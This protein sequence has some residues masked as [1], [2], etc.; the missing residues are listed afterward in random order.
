MKRL[1]VRP[2]FRGRGIG[3]ALAN[4][5]ILA[6]KQ[7]G[8]RAMRL[9]TLPSMTEAHSLYREIG[10]REITAYRHNPVSGTRF[11]ELDLSGAPTAN[12]KPGSK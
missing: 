9:D 3:R 11:L 2:E 12:A 8:Y 6:A 1:Y 5:L 10:F 7:I 4:F